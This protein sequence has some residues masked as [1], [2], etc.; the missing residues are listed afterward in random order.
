[1]TNWIY[2]DDGSIEPYSVHWKKKL[3]PTSFKKWDKKS[4]QYKYIKCGSEEHKKIMSYRGGGQKVTCN[5][6]LVPKEISDRWYLSEEWKNCRK[7]YLKNYRKTNKLR[8][9]NYCGT[10]EEHRKMHIDHIYPVR[11]YWSMRLDHANL[12]NL[13]EICNAQKGNHMENSVATRKL[14][15]KDNKWVVLE[16]NEEPFVC[17]DW[18]KNDVEFNWKE[19]T[20]KLE[21]ITIKRKND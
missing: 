9:C 19:E 5:P 10:T 7:E 21:L 16:I 15:K 2:N 6:I 18:L 20:S 13:C 8:I 11:R 1:M 17:P 4:E 12:Q 3:S 14:I